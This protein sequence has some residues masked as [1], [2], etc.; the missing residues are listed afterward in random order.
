MYKRCDS[1]HNIVTHVTQLTALFLSKL[2]VIANDITGS[3]FYT[4]NHYF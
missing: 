4:R 2:I 3:V 1:T